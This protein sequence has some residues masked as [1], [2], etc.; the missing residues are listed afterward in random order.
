MQARRVKKELID[1]YIKCK[2]WLLTVTTARHARVTPCGSVLPY[3]CR[4]LY[5]SQK[6]LFKVFLEMLYLPICLL[7]LET[8]YLLKTEKKTG[9]P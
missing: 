5:M 6:A 7:H 9:R 1:I 3:F 8:G 4:R 2:V